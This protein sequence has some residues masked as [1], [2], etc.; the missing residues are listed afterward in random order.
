MKRT[1]DQC[2]GNCIY[3]RAK[4]GTGFT[5]ATFDGICIWGQTH[6]PSCQRDQQRMNTHHDQGTACPV[7]RRVEG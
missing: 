2:C 4:Q 1:H 5:Y 7:W 6:V 3:Y